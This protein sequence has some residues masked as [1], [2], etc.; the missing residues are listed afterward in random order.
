MA[1]ALLPISIPADV[2]SMVSLGDRAFATDLLAQ[3]SCPSSIPDRFARKLKDTMVMLT[4]VNGAY[5]HAV[6]IIV[7]EDREEAMAGAAGATGAGS[8]D[9]GGGGAAGGGGEEEE[10][11]EGGEGGVM[12]GYALWFA[13]PPPSS[14]SV[15]AAAETAA[16]AEVAARQARWADVS[17][18][19]AQPTVTVSERIIAGNN[20]YFGEDWRSLWNLRTL[21][22]APEYQGRGIGT[23]LVQ[24]GVEA[25]RA[26]AA[27][28]PAGEVRGLYAVST[29]AGLRV[30]QKAGWEAKGEEVFEVGEGTYKFVWMVMRFDGSG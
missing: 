8:L 19:T 27:A 20:K 25:A 9:G 23:R 2:E 5:A 24:W 11:E 22:V 4:G 12:A 1:M 6:K 18:A 30:Y 29:S 13:P 28:R 10:E 21:A 15:A 7:K 26:D 17:P 16:K 14:P 3:A